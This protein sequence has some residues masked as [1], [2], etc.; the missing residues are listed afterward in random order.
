MKY[1]LLAI[2]ADQICGILMQ[3]KIN[4]ELS[5]SLSLAAHFYNVFWFSLTKWLKVEIKPISRTRCKQIFLTLS[6]NVR[7]S[8]ITSFSL[9]DRVLMSFLIS[10]HIYVIQFSTF[11]IHSI[12]LTSWYILV[13]ISIH[14]LLKFNNW[15]QVH[16]LHVV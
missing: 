6:L 16:G 8:S 12:Q 11:N 13:L 9:N 3:K 1:F 4:A 14:I 15:I 10:W 5:M 7:N 2:T